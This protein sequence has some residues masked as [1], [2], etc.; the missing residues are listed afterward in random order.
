MIAYA[1]WKQLNTKRERLSKKSLS[2]STINRACR[3][4]TDLG[5]HS[6]GTFLLD[7]AKGFGFA[8]GM[9]K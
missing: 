2:L 4:S 8:Y 7:I 5:F 3:I 1:P 9:F 6:P